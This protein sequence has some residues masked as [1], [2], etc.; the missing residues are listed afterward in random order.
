MARQFIIIVLLFTFHLNVFAQNDLKEDSIDQDRMPAS[1]G[2]LGDSITA[3]VLASFR[4][5]E[6]WM[7][8][9]EFLIALKVLKLGISKEPNSLTN[10]QKS[11]AAGWDKQS[12][13]FSHARRLS[14]IQNLK[15]QIPTF[16]AAVSGDESKHVLNEQLDNLKSWSQQNINQAFP[17]YVT[18][19][20][21][22]NDI[23]AE[24]S[25]HMV[26]V[27]TYYSNIQ[28]TVD[29]ILASSPNSKLLV[30]SLP[31]I[32]NLRAVA[33]DAKLHV[34]LSCEKLWE[35]VNLCPTLTTEDDPIERQIIG[36]RVLEYNQALKDIVESRR[37]V[38]GD[39]VRFAEKTY[40]AEFNKDHLSVD[41]FHP[42]PEGQEL[43]ADTTF[44]SS[45]WADK[46]ADKK[47]QIKKRELKK[48]KALC[49]AQRASQG[50]KATGC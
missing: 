14:E 11:W 6:F 8:W 40:E 46:W 28:K 36:Q 16:N 23:C 30:G 27:E 15:K 20:V 17:D 10:P 9:N 47:E 5:S 3:G 2:A 34:G 25:R 37:D 44:A 38:Y 48:K 32:E 45:W 31:N 1:M 18:I 26:P 24:S 4:R 35:T 13:V 29:E 19:M 43:L 50:G 41:C 39:R 22:P 12:E 33:K 49:N 42:N 7:P 21:G